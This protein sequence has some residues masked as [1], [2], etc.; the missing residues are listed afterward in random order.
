VEELQKSLAVKR[1]ELE[2]K[3]NEA[4]KK[5]K[6]MMNN[7]QEAEKKK[8]DSEELKKILQVINY[9]LKFYKKIMLITELI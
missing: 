5:L 8:V 7:K 2:K 9:D 6:K 1:T 4:D 3:N